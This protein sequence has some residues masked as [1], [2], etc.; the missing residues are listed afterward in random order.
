MRIRNGFAHLLVPWSLFLVIV[1]KTTREKEQSHADSVYGGIPR[2][3][4]RQLPGE[5][6]EMASRGEDVSSYYR[7]N[8]ELTLGCYDSSMSGLPASMS[9]GK[10]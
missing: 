8:V 6:A 10:Q 5:I 7:V 2:Q 1:W 9:A 3:Q 4:R